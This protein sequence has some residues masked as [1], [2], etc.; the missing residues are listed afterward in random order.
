MSSKKTKGSKS[1]KTRSLKSK[2]AKPSNSAKNKDNIKILPIVNKVDEDDIEVSDEDID[3][4]KEHAQYTGFLRTI[5]PVALHRS[6]EINKEQ[7]AKYSKRLEEIGE[8]H[9]SSN[10]DDESE[11]DLESED[12]NQ[13]VN[14][15]TEQEYEKM[16]R[17]NKE[18][19]PREPVK[20]PI[21][22]PDGK[23]QH[24]ETVV[25]TGVDSKNEDNESSTSDPVFENEMEIKKPSEED[26]KSLPDQKIPDK[27][28]FIQKKEELAEIAQKIIE[29][30][31]K[32]VGQ[33][34]TLREIA[35][36]QDTKIRRLALLVQLV[37]YKDIIPGYRV[38]NLTD[39][40]KAAHVSKDVKKIR[41]FEES[42]VANYQAYLKSLET[43]LREQSCAEV[44][45]QCLCDLLTSVTHFNFRSNLMTIIVQRM[46]APELNKMSVMCCNAI[47]RVFREDESGE[48]SLDAVKLLTKMIKSRQYVVHEEVLNTFLHLRLR[49][50][51]NVNSLRDDDKSKINGKKRK[52]NKHEPKKHLSRKMRKLEK[53]R[54]EIEKEV[55]EAEAVVDKDEKEKLHTETLKLVFI[56]YFRIL[57]HADSSP[58]LSSV[59]EGLAKFAHLIN[60]DFF[61]DLLEV[62]KKI[63]GRETNTRRGLLCIITAFQLLSGQG[64]ALNI[65]LQDFYTQLYK[66]LIPLALDANNDEIKQRTK[67]G[68]EGEYSNAHSI[69]T[70]Y[71]LLMKGFDFM[72]F[73]RRTIP[74]D[75]SAAFLKRLLISCLNWPGKTVLSCLEKM[76]KM[77]QQHPKLDALLTSDDMACGGVYRPELDDP[78][79]CNPFATSLWEL[80]LLEKHYNPKVRAAAHAL[81]TIAKN[82]G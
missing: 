35:T 12:E 59:L 18:W 20:L 81:S 34:K 54:K 8:S 53:E 15:D 44:A 43:E 6:K 31:E 50:E 65:D 10:E 3:F 7:P 36:D 51:L 29:D 9:S 48:A 14:S 37:V 41:Q 74:I 16:P 62:L 23:L 5:D 4:F 69:A 66:I 72:F 40:E 17:V 28:Y 63:M 82:N 80:C 13:I 61:S 30:P 1:S 52:L 26:G 60:V 64:E 42:L 46:S 33:L 67:K 57:K 47:I 11:D 77:I 75:R 79:L 58:L 56:T 39:K 19:I 45:L 2:N 55:R 76:E 27:L 78:E 49:D 21:K 73:R 71:Q 70:D 68:N 38:R 24:Q 32:N 25:G 22:L